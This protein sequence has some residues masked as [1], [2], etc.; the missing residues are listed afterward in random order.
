LD[1]DFERE[2]V[3]D[4]G[5]HV[6]EVDLLGELRLHRLLQALDVSAEVQKAVCVGE[7]PDGRDAVVRRKG[8]GAE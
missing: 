8:V 3:V 6:G 1:W 2:E 5:G 7:E 4:A